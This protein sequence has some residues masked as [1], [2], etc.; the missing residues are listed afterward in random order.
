MEDVTG[1]LSTTSRTLDLDAVVGKQSHDK[2]SLAVVSLR[3]ALVHFL[4]SL[5]RDVR[6]EETQRQVVDFA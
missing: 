4:N 6:G 3:N 5:H 1:V 2:V